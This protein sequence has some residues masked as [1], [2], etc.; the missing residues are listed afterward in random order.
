MKKNND[1]VSIDYIN[2]HN[3]TCF[4]KWVGAHWIPY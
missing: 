3:N 1:Y 4:N 2:E